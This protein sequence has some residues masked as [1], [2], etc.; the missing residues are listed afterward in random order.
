MV[1]TT[2]S[3]RRNAEQVGSAVTAL[4]THSSR[5]QRHLQRESK[6]IGKKTHNQTQWWSI[7]TRRG[8]QCVS[9]TA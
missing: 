5:S 1:R 2:R 9:I 3:N 4:K 6:K 8:A 7:N